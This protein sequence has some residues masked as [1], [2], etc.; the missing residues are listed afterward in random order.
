MEIKPGAV[1]VE[2][3]Q[4]IFSAIGESEP[5]PQEQN[6]DPGPG[7]GPGPDPDPDPC[8][9]GQCRD[10]DTEL[11]RP[12]GINERRNPTTGLCEPIAAPPPARISKFIFWG[13]NDTTSDAE[14]VLTAIMQQTGVSAYLFVGDGPY[15]STATNWINMMNTYFDS[16]KKALL[17]LAQG[18]HEHPESESQTTENQIEAW[19]PGLNN[20]V[21]GLEWLSFR[22]VGNVFIINMNSQDPNLNTV[23]GDQY[24]YVQ[25]RLNEAVAL[26]D[27][28]EINFIIVVIHKS[29]FNL[30]SSNQSY[31][32]AR[33][34]YDSMFFAAQVDFVL[35]GHNHNKHYWN[36]GRPII[37]NPSNTAMTPTF[38]LTD[39]GKYD[40]E[41]SHGPIHLIEGAGGHEHNIFGQAPTSNVIFSDDVHFGY[42]MITIQGKQATIESYDTGNNK[43]F[44]APIIT[45][46]TDLPPKPDPDPGPNPG[47]FPPCPRGQHRDLEGA[48]V[49]NNCRPGDKWDPTANGGQGGCVSADTPINCGPGQIYD[50]DLQQCVPDNNPQPTIRDFAGVAVGDFDCNSR[51]DRTF[52]MIQETWNQINSTE[53]LGYLFALGDMSYGSSQTCWLQRIDAL[54]IFFP[55]DHTFPIIGNHDDVEDGSLSKRNAIINGFSCFP[56]NRGFYALTLGAALVIFM[57]TQS[58]YDEGSAQHTFVTQQL[59]AAQSDGLVKW[60]IVCYHKPSIV[61]DTDH[62]PLTDFRDIYHPMFDQYRV[63]IALS[64]HNHLYHR[65]FPL[66][67]NSSSPSNPIVGSTKTGE[68]RAGQIYTGKEGTI[69]FTIGGGGRTADSFS[70]DQEE[71]ICSRTEEYGIVTFAC[72]DNGNILQFAFHSHNG[73]KLDECILSR[74]VT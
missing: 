60:I 73:D 51:T 33:E 39:D 18:N 72:T 38:S 55:R 48:C 5:V 36:P 63:N 62:G 25:E 54:K 20:P 27:R 4:S 12:P 15:A 41:K 9:T 66:K 70:G 17:M 31:V 23:G 28:G 2:G 30:L 69:Y 74:N 53:D 34:T 61:S 21:E 32:L 11:C 71:Y 43:L 59:Q 68:N 26:R 44:T 58:D 1:E 19:Y 14:D 47:P 49:P 6:P 13:D 64:G 57:D 16:I 40:F 37:G 35:H 65:S 42:G 52:E 22:I 7:P 67:H 3:V 29:W 50:E 8:P 46:G 24:K 10:P 45:R 56:D